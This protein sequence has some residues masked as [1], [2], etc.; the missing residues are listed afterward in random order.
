MRHSSLQ[1][2]SGS[3]EPDR[4]AVLYLTNNLPC[5]PNSGGQLR[6]YELL[7]RLSLRFAVHLVAFVATKAPYGA[8]EASGGFLASITEV[9]TNP[10]AAPAGMPLRMRLHYAP[11]GAAEVRSVF[12]RHPFV[13]A[14]VEGY[15]LM[16]YLEGVPQ[17]PVVLAAENIEFALEEQ[18]E[19]L[20]YEDFN[21]SATMVAEIDAWQRATVCVCVTAEDTE[22]VR[23]YVSTVPVRCVTDGVDHLPDIPNG[24][25]ACSQ[26][27]RTCLYVANYSWAPSR[28]AAVHLLR[29]IW[30]AICSL[31]PGSK[32]VLAGCGLDRS[33]TEEAV[34]TND[35]IIYGQYGTFAEV[36]SIA[37]LFV[38]PM[39]FGG[40]I[41]VKIIEAIGAGLPIVTTATAL[42]GFPQEVRQHVWLA[43][44]P[45]AFAEMAARALAQIED[46]T[47]R[48]DSAKLLLRS[49]M[50]T[51]ADLADDL[52]TIWEHASNDR[53]GNR[54]IRMV[55]SLP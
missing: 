14:H 39:R 41:K 51:W 26:A 48:A 55:S 5:P 53:R 20:G 19:A 30:P 15:F 24:K 33:L 22:V 32:L 21:A 7:R 1:L 54:T 3:P 6:E 13:L 2:C 44:S 11:A 28:D 47:T 45:Q 29:D 34:Q 8:A 36:A 25:L 50:P 42:R 35:V 9:V 31:V 46:R 52:A 38:F 12:R 17:I 4:P 10:G 37:D 27:G 18:A 49:L 23:Q 40:G 16:H 43:N